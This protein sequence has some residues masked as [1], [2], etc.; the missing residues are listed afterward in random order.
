[1]KSII[2]G[3][4][5]MLC[6]TQFFAQEKSVIKAFYSGFEEGLYVFVDAYEEPHYFD[7]VEKKLLVTYPLDKGEF[8]N[9]AFEITYQVLNEGEEDETIIISALSLTKITEEEDLNED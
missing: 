9:E 6:F 1:M 3:L 4:T 8:R 2:S 7:Q 5:M